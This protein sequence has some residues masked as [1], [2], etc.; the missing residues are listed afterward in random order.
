[1]P[2]GFGDREV[3]VSWADG[4]HDVFPIEGIRRANKEEVL[5]AYHTDATEPIGGVQHAWQRAKKAAWIRVCGLGG[6]TTAL[7]TLWEIGTTAMPEE[8][9]VSCPGG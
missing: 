6:C 2:R 7:A 1:M 8:M 3:A 9:P 5:I 4:H